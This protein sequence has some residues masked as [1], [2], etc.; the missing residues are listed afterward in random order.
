VQAEQSKLPSPDVPIELPAMAHW[1]EAWSNAKIDPWSLNLAPTAS[2][3]G[4]A[5]E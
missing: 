2:P 1:L 5:D 3:R 4:E